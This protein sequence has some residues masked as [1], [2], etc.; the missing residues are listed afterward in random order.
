MKFRIYLLFPLWIFGT[1]LPPSP[2][3]G[4]SPSQV[5]RFAILPCSNIETTFG[6]YYPLLVYLQKETGR[7]LKLV[8]PSNMEEFSH[9]LAGGSIDFALQDPHTYV[10]LS[11]YFHT[12]GLLQAL[13]PEGGATQ[14]GVVVVR[15]D[16]VIH[17]L[18]DLKDKTVMFG[19]KV[20]TVK[21]V[22]ARML[23][24]AAGIR[25]DQD[26]KEYR[27][28]GCCEDIAFSV[29]VKSVDAGVICDHFMADHREKQQDM[30]VDK[31]GLR[32][33]ART[34]PFPTRIFASSLGVP[35]EVRTKL[36]QAFL[37]LDRENPEHARLLLRGEFGGFQ[38]AADADYDSMRR[39]MAWKRPADK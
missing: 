17:S 5:Y 26:L 37:A 14:S 27:F 38:P 21:W 2:A 15:S 33:I 35:G 28:G 36:R 24:E 9:F 30:G 34:D 4:K 3:A 32:V 13:S 11:R 6:K 39:A 31:T 20:S 1:F 12:D 23:F 10:T 16:S 18:P 25:I 29:S 8:V 22:A 19:P 7:E